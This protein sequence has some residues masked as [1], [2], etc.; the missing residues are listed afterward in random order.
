V[1]HKEAVNPGILDLLRLLMEWPEMSA[2]Y[3]VGGTSLALRSGYR[4]S[5]DLDLFTEKEFDAARLREGIEREFV[6]CEIT[7]ISR[8]TVIAYSRGFKID[9]IQHL[10]PLLDSIDQFEGIRFVSLRDLSAMKINAVAG[11]GSKKDFSDLLYLH[12]Q[13]ISLEESI[14]NYKLKYG[15]SSVFS[16]YKSLSYFGDTLG[17]PDPRYLNGWT[18]DAVRKRMETL[19][20]ETQ[21]RLERRR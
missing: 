7:S 15:A 17:E 14:E 19:G 12:D 4:Q 3:L 9:I 5:D 21:L 13:G 1:I 2:F 8:G 20:L 10:Y 6:D 18:W 16:V 11:R